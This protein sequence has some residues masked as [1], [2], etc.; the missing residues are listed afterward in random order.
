MI[1][2]VYIDSHNP[3]FEYVYNINNEVEVQFFID[4]LLRKLPKNSCTIAKMMRY[5]EDII[6]RPLCNN[7]RLTSGHSIVFSHADDGS[8]IAIDPQQETKRPSMDAERA[9]IAWKRACYVSISVMV[10]HQPNRYPILNADEIVN[11]AVYLPI[12]EPMDVDDEPMGEPMDVDDEPMDVDDE[13]MDIGGGQNLKKKSN[14]HIKKH[15]KKYIKKSKRKNMKR[16]KTRKNK[17]KPNY[18]YI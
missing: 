3:Q 1:N 6:V 4:D 17:A 7:V 13:S 2:F 11:N 16:I 12:H 5:P 9:L 18:F 14:K 8:L 15:I 10:S